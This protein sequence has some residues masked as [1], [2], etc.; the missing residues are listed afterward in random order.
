MKEP[1][2]WKQ[3]RRIVFLLSQEFL[4]CLSRFRLSH[5]RPAHPMSFISPVIVCLTYKKL[6]ITP[7]CPGEGPPARIVIFHPVCSM[8]DAPIAAR[9]RGSFA[10]DLITK[11][12]RFTSTFQSPPQFLQDWPESCRN[13]E[14]S[15]KLAELGRTGTEFSRIPAKLEYI[16]K[17]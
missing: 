11:V 13:P 1:F 2:E 6:M 9:D 7:S 16:F 8:S 4:K 17:L 3:K 10:T 14:D 15:G 5:M 12:S